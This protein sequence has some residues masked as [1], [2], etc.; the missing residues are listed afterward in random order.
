[1]PALTL[2]GRI[3]AISLLVALQAASQAQPVVA[4]PQPPATNFAATAPV[5]TPF[6]NSVQ[7]S[8]PAL[9]D[10]EQGDLLM[11]NKRYQAAVEAYSKIAQPSAALWNR[12]GIAY[13]MLFDTKDATRCY[14]TSLKLDPNFSG[15]INNLATIEDGRRDFATAERLY[16]KALKLDPGSA[17]ILKNLGTNLLMQH[18]YSE[19]SEAYAQALA[20]DSHI[21]DQ[22]SGP[23][24]E[25]GVSTRDRGEESYLWARNCAR[26]GLNACAVTQLRKA[27]YEGS[28]TTKQVATEK[29]FEAMRQTPEFERLLAEQQ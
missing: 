4:A 10:E 27:F 11:M 18:K 15:A 8:P 28:A 22:Y 3:S 9:T 2:F 23:T 7:P 21:L 25:A 19:S 17:R 5:D 13:Q 29:D 14:K 16:R 24:I 6:P 12:K 20:I 26:A 1:M